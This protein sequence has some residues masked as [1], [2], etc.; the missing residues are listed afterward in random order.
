MK[1]I[2][3]L[4]L[5]LGLLFLGGCSSKSVEEKLIDS[6][7][8]IDKA[9]IDNIIISNKENDSYFWVFS[10][11][12][13]KAKHISYIGGELND[14]SADPDKSVL[15]KGK[16]EKENTDSAIKI[17]ENELRRIGITEKELIEYCESLK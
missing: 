16:K 11:E 1:K 7:Y 9:N 6:G 5:I 3:S 4:V 12:A 13:S 15:I 8:T 10:Y 17:Y 2:F 14:G